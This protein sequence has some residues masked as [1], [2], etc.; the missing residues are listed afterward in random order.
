[1]GKQDF[2]GKA[3]PIFSFSLMQTSSTIR[4]KSLSSSSPLFPTGS[5]LS[6]AQGSSKEAISPVTAAP[7]RRSSHI[8]PASSPRKRL[9]TQNVATGRS[10]QGQ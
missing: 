9:L 3:A 5:T 8:S 2:M 10:P 1:M 4:T 6:S 7:G